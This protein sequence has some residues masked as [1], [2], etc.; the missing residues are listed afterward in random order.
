M[1]YR[2]NWYHAL[3]HHPSTAFQQYIACKRAVER[4]YDCSI[5]EYINLPMIG[6]CGSCQERKHLTK[7]PA[8]TANI[9]GGDI[10]KEQ[11]L[12]NSDGNHDDR[13]LDDTDIEG[14]NMDAVTF[15]DTIA[16]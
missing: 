7:K 12:P 4:G 1:C 16:F 11:V 2:I 8:S 13:L 5:S 3:C 6:R 15:L 10:P 14:F 9:R